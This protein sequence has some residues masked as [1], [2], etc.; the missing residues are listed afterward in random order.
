M[1]A[2]PFAALRSWLHRVVT[3][4]RQL[5]RDETRE[6]EGQTFAA[7]L[8]TL[9]ARASARSGAQVGLLW[10]VMLFAT[11][12]ARRR[13]AWLTGVVDAIRI[14][15][16]MPHAN[17]QDHGQLLSWLWHLLANVASTTVRPTS[18]TSQSAM[19]APG[20]VELKRLSSAAVAA[21][22][23]LPAR[24]NAAGSDSVVNGQ[25]GEN[26]QA[27]SD[28]IALMQSVEGDCGEPTS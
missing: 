27:W 21:L 24:C 2:T 11:M 10:Q 25:L 22:E 19:V 1:A 28:N 12:V 5:A 13:E 6:Q 23:R 3:E 8:S 9:Y 16:A 7:Q 26:S 14:A 4:V 18:T 17:Q 20:D 15:T